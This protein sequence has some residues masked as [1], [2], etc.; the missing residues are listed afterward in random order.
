M[1]AVKVV[2]IIFSTESQIDEKLAELAITHVL[3]RL[4]F[5]LMGVAVVFAAAVLVDE[6][7]PTGDDH[8][9]VVPN[10]LQLPRAGSIAQSSG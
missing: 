1:A 2:A 9:A 6:E 10:D 5:S 4:A 3:I 7:R 8:G